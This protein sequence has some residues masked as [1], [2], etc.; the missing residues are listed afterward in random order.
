MFILTKSNQ[1]PKPK[2][3]LYE[4]FPDV[5][6]SIP[7]ICIINETNIN[8]AIILN[9]KMLREALLA[10]PE[11]TKKLLGIVVTDA[12]VVTTKEPTVKK[13]PKKP[14]TPKTIFKPIEDVTVEEVTN[15]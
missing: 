15:E 12:T 14:S 13:A 6:A 2:R 5:E 3:T 7:D 1:T 4:G 8:N 11:A 10:N 9:S